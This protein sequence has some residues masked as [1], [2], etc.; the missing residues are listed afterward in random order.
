MEAKGSGDSRSPGRPGLAGSLRPADRELRA[1]AAP[2]AP[3]SVHS[4]PPGLQNLGGGSP[5]VPHQDCPP[6]LAL[7]HL[8]SFHPEPSTHPTGTKG[9]RSRG[10]GNPGFLRPQGPCRQQASAWVKEE[11][12][13]ETGQ[14]GRSRQ[15]HRG[16]GSGQRRLRPGS[17]TWSS[18]RAAYRGLLEG[19]G[20]VSPGTHKPGLR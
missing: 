2:W 14:K 17:Q 3:P 10:R 20:R 7:G 11:E 18:P 13:R 6:H 4:K 8:L 16:R 19:K 5:L 15:G 1:C 9:C 12:E